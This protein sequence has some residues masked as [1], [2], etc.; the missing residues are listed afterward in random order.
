M[1]NGHLCFEILMTASAQT[2]V[3]EARATNESFE[4]QG[5]V[6]SKTRKVEY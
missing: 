5:I 1:G 3:A 6:A 2:D 4:K